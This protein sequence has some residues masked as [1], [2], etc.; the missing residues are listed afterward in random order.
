MSYATVAEMS[1]RV[2]GGIPAADEPRAQAYLDD[3]TA[4]IEEETGRV[5]SDVPPTAHQVCLSAALRA[6]F[7]P[8]FVASE[9]LGDYQTRYAALGGVYLTP[10]ERAE[11]GKL[12]SSSALWVQPLGRRD[13]LV[14]PLDEYVYVSDRPDGGSFPFVPDADA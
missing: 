13:R 5:F 2:P 1:V 3:A 9:G 8:S 14:H 11:L 10:D 4:L 12:K 7:N 6:W